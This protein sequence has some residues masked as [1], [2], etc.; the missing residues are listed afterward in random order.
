MHRFEILYRTTNG[1]IA[2]KEVSEFQAARELAKTLA[3]ATGRRTVIRR[4]PQP[5]WK[6]ILVDLQTGEN[7]E[8]ASQLTKRQAGLIWA[9]WKGRNLQAVC[10]PWPEWAEEPQIRVGDPG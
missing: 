9:K 10:V 4:K 7:L 1:T 3:Q 5:G 8:T 2:I 6:I